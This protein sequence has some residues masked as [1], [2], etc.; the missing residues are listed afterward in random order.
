[1]IA[2]FLTMPISST[3]PMT[4]TMSTSSPASHSASSA[5]TP[6]DGSVDRMV[7]GWMV[8]SYSTPSTMYMVT[9]A[10]KMSSSVFDNEA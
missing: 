10:A 6:A 7:T 2:F 3:M 4:A 5:P 1:M 9:T 8:L